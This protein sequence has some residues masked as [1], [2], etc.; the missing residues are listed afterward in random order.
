MSKSRKADIDQFFSS[1]RIAV[2]GVSREPQHFSRAV[3]RAM[4]DRGMHLIPVHPDADA[5][6]GL[7]AYR[8]VSEI[9]DKVDAVLVMTPPHLSFAV[10]KNAV[11]AGV[12]RVWLY[13]D[14]PEAEAYC[15][16]KGAAIIADECPFMFLDHA[17]FIHDFH[18]GLRWITRSLLA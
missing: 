6:E 8:Q 17:G 1:E 15:R 12:R 4:V 18:R 14:C 5:I 16:E 10:A 3:F 13:R 7:R 11:D 2:A 9:P